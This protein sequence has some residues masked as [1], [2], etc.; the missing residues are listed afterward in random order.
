MFSHKILTCLSRSVLSL[1]DENKVMRIKEIMTY[2][3]CSCQKPKA[4]R[5]S[6]KTTPWWTQPG[7]RE[8]TWNF[9]LVHRPMKYH[10]PGVRLTDRQC[11]NSLCN[12]KALK[13]RK[14]SFQRMLYTHV[15]VCVL[16]YQARCEHSSV[17]SSDGG[18]WC[19][20]HT[21]ILPSRSQLFFCLV[22]QT[23]NRDLLTGRF[24]SWFNCRSLPFVV[25]K[26]IFLWF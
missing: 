20:C 14:E 15:Q 21:P 8:T 4:W 12:I 6:C 9:F 23:L 18:I 16:T 19:K 7:P 26:W 11:Y 22:H 25:Q 10:K 17:P 2:L 1:T 5:S 3:D 13:K 24:S